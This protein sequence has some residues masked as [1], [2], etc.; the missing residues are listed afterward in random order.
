MTSEIEKKYLLRE[1][2]QEYHT[3][4]LL[5]HFTSI[6]SLVDE[7]ETKGQ[8]IKQGYLSLEEGIELAN[9]LGL[10]VDFDPKEARLRD[11]AGTCY[12]TIK[13]EGDL[14]RRELEAK[15]S[16]GI[17]EEYWVATEGKRVEKISLTKPAG[18]YNLE[19]DLYT[20]RDLIVLEVEFPST[21]EANSF[22]A[23]GLDL[24]ANKDYKNKNLAR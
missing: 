1:R 8:A 20:D 17:F 6:D 4:A 15:I 19:V 10:E 11:K 23:L 5:E 7:I 2:G 3:G 24:T 16:Q 9:T 13:G 14:Q 12:L 21:E 18:Q 22:T